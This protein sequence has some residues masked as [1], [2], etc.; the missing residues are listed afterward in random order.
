VASTL[1]GTLPDRVDALVCIEGLGPMSEHPRHAP[2][3]FAKSIADQIGK[4]TKR[5]VV[6]ASID[7]A[8]ERLGSSIARL[9]PAAARVL[10]ERGLVEV[11]GGV[12]WRTDPRLRWASRA[13]LVEAQVLAFL[14][15]ITCPALLVRA[16]AGL[17]F[18]SAELEARVAA[19]AGWRHATVEGSHHVHLEAPD[20]VAAPI[21]AFLEEL[22]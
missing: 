15:A 9:S 19:V 12:T 21:A 10:C 14:T 2:F 4:A 20:L 18:Y 7:A 11:D 3:R 13:R 1:A 16:T 8:I 6:H 17:P 5:P 22:A